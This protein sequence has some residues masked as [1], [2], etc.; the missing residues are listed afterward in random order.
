ME[1][2]SPRGCAG[3][4]VSGEVEPTPEHHD[5]HGAESPRHDRADHPA[6]RR[7]AS[8]T[9]QVT[10]HLRA[11][12]LLART[13]IVVG[14]L[15]GL[16]AMHGLST[17]HD[18]ATSSAH[19]TAFTM[20]ANEPGHLLDVGEHA[21]AADGLSMPPHADIGQACC[22]AV[23]TGAALL[24]LFLVWPLQVVR[25]TEH[26]RAAGRPWRT[27]QAHAPPRPPDLAALC[28]LRI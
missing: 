12:R 4:Y 24:I 18:A 1:V 21:A 11:R 22:V 8:R 20:N 13:L 9:A 19:Q 28:V 6:R 15:A 5:Q 27:V 16:F 2:A 25:V 26:L 3:T 17:D 7:I 14:L 10:G 23:L